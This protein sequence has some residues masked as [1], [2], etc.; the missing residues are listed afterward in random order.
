MIRRATRTHQVSIRLF[1][2]STR[3]SG[4]PFISDRTSPNIE[5]SNRQLEVSLYLSSRCSPVCG[6]EINAAMPL[7]GLLN[8]GV[9]IRRKNQAVFIL[10]RNQSSFQHTVNCW[11]WKSRNGDYWNQWKNHERLYSIQTQSNWSCG[12]TNWLNFHEKS[13]FDTCSPSINCN[14]HCIWKRLYR[15]FKDPMTAPI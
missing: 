3:W 5:S 12:V 11:R 15:R 2:S 1:F 14:V 9:A 6:A 10:D 4:N 8:D 7:L 13:E